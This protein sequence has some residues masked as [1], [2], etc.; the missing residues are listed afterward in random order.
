MSI[1]MFCHLSPVVPAAVGGGTL[2]QKTRS[3]GEG[4]PIPHWLGEAVT[5]ANVGML[6]AGV[7]A[8]AIGKANIAIAIV[9]AR[10]RATVVAFL[11]FE[12]CILSS[13]FNYTQFA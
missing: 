4:E 11:F 6:H 7:C 12:N 13:P 10:N 3:R 1:V 5:Y 2:S 9:N 8:L